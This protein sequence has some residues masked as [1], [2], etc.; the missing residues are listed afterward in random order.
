MDSWL[1]DNPINHVDFRWTTKLDRGNQFGHLRT[2]EIAV[3][4]LIRLSVGAVVTP[5][6]PASNLREYLA[7][8]HEYAVACFERVITEE[9]RSFISKKREES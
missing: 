4:S 9:F 5:A 7:T 1:G 6:G 2:D 8:A 3:G